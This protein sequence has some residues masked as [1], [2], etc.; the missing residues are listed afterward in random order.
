[1]STAVL[2]Y[3]PAGTFREIAVGRRLLRDF[4]QGRVVE[5]AI[6][7]SRGLALFPFH[8]ALTVLL[9]RGTRVLVFPGK[10]GI[11]N[12]SADLMMRCVE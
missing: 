11:D 4:I 9:R 5:F 1:M 10:R 8:I 3:E 2:W 12:V 7:R 6:A